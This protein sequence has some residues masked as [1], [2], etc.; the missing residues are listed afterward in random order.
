MLY[1]LLKTEPS[2]YSWQDLLKEKR[3]AWT[4]VRNFGARNHLR[5][6]KKGDLVFVYHSGDEKAVE[7][8]KKPITLEAI[9]KH[10]ALKDMVLVKNSRLSVQPVTN[11]EWETCLHMYD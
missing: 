1:W 8:L 7:S 4:G 2:T 5:A 10:N 11:Q 6:M 9:K 3:T